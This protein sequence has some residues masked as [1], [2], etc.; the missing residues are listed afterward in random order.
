[1]LVLLVGASYAYFLVEVNSSNTQTVVTG[2]TEGTSIASIQNPTEKLNL[3]VDGAAMSLDNLGTIY[4]DDEENY[5]KTKSEGFHDIGVITLTNP[6]KDDNIYRCTANVTITVDNGSNSILN[7]LQ[8]DDLKVFLRWGT[9]HQV[10]DLSTLKE[11][12]ETTIPISLDIVGN[13]SKSIETYIE[14]TN[15]DEDQSYISGKDINI[16]IDTTDLK[17]ELTGEKAVYL[18][19]TSW[20]LGIGYKM[21]HLTDIKNVYFVNYIDTSNAVEEP[22]DLTNIGTK[23]HQSPAGSIMGWI[24]EIPKETDEEEQFYNLYIGSKDKIYGVIYSYFFHNMI[25]LANV[26]YY[27]FN[28]DLSSTFNRFLWGTDNISINEYDVSRFDTSNVKNMTFMFSGLNQIKELDVSNFNTKNVANMGSMFHEVE[29]TTELDVSNF[30]TM[31][32]TDMSNMFQGMNLLTELDVSGFYTGNV[33]NMLSMFYGMSSLQKLDVS[34]FDT[35]NV[36]NMSNMFR[37]MSSLTELDVSGFYTRNVT[38]MESMFN[39]LSQ[40]QKLDLSKFVTNNITNMKNMFRGM[41]SLEYLDLR[42]AEFN[43]VE[44]YSGMFNGVKND[45]TI[46]VNEANK[47]WIEARLKEEKITGNVLLPNEIEES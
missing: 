37:G 32:V 24:E 21:G 44:S 13:N 31:K 8:P 45:I 30:N 38:N 42:N 6:K 17:C 4:A 40:V 16:D 18:T 39:G 27:N 12:N 41:S 2:S 43:Q 22:V 20:T 47:E 35:H 33:I 5:V 14:L 3:N 23:E 9:N 26:S 7:Y 15:K 34:K 19:G 46:I 36:T 29:S 11:K 1:M 25:N 10:I 28:S